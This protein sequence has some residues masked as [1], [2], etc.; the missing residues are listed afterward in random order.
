MG[1]LCTQENYR[2]MSLLEYKNATLIYL[3][4]STWRF[5]N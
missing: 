5:E 1:V 4:I 2:N 3:R